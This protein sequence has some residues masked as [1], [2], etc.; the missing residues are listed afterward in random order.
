[1][2]LDYDF[3]AVFMYVHPEIHPL[4]D[5]LTDKRAK[6]FFDT[7]WHP[8]ILRD[9]RLPAVL[10]RGYAVLPNQI[11]AECMTGA[12]SA[13]EAARRLAAFL[14]VAVVK[15]GERG[16]LACQDGELISVQAFPI[17]KVVD[18][19]GA[20]DAFNAGF[21]YGTL[22]GYPLAEALRCGTIC[23]SL[24]TTAITG[25]A[26]VPTAQELEQLRLEHAR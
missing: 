6:I 21:I 3:D 12:Q 18:T 22:K 4:L 2:L 10:R 24:S 15:V 25:T 13:E 5:I 14:P 17:Q 1:M 7:G 19:T 26:A 8:E 11:E 23:G 16:V 20:G 9:P